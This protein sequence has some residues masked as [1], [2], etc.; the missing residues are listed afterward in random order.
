MPE[1][2]FEHERSDVP[3]KVPAIVVVVTVIAVAASIMLVAALVNRVWEPAPAGPDVFG[4]ERSPGPAPVLQQNPRAD[5]EQ[6]QR[7]WQRRLHSFGWVDREA[8]IVHVPI[9][10][11]MDRIARNGLPGEERPGDGGGRE[12]RQ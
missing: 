8:G 1:Q 10:A 9:E 12:D 5:M 11:A 2:R 3:G 4:S 7:R 6:L